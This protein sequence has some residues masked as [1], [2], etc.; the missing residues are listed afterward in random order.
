M[1]KLIQFIDKQAVWSNISNPVPGFACRTVEH[2]DV[3]PS[4]IMLEFSC[5][6]SELGSVSH[7]RNLLCFKAKDYYVSEIQLIIN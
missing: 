5:K 1:I 2:L 6:E 4:N 7:D 3:L